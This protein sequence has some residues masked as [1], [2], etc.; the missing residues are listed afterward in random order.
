MLEVLENILVLGEDDSWSEKQ[1]K[2]LPNLVQRE[3]D[4]PAILAVVSPE[5]EG[6]KQERAALVKQG[7]KHLGSFQ[8]YGP[9]RNYLYGKGIR[10]AK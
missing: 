9:Y 2:T 10:K 6:W 3:R 4:E 5:H 1:A 7:F 8:G